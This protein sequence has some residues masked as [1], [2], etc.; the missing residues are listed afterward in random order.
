MFDVLWVSDDTSHY[1]ADLYCSRR[2]KSETERK[3]I[4]Q[5]DLNKNLRT[6]R[7][8]VLADVRDGFNKS[9]AE[10][11][12]S[13]VI[14][15]ESEVDGKKVRMRPTSIKEVEE[16]TPEV[17]SLFGYRYDKPKFKTPYL[18]EFSAADKSGRIFIEKQKPFKM[19]LTSTR[20]RCLMGWQGGHP[21]KVERVHGACKKNG[22]FIN[23]DY[24]W[25]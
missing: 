24:Y 23:E 19:V 5:K 10:K 14:Y 15:L 12:P 9:L 1:C 7:F 25:V 6:I 20:N 4:L 18:V 21:V 8:Y 11:N 2:G 3:Q 22:K 13:W 16:L 17:L